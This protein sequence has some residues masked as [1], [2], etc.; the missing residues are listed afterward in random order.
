MAI[1]N[2]KLCNYRTVRLVTGKAATPE[3]WWSTIYAAHFMLEAQKAGY[4]VNEKFLTKL[5][6]YLNARLR[7]KV[8]FKYFSDGSKIEV[9]KKKV[10]Y[11]LYVLALA[12]EQER[13]S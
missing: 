12:T 6:D 7:T 1:E 2:Y 4:T 13:L 3:S 11:S 10:P 9:V 5:F 8:E